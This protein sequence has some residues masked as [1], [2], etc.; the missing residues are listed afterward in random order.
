MVSQDKN[1]RRGNV[2]ETAETIQVRENWDLDNG[3]IFGGDEERL[4]SC[5]IFKDIGTI[6]RF[7]C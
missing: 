4:N 7:V 3:G 5:H 6:C 2:Q 1:G